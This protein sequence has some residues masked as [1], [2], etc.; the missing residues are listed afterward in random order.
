MEIQ[1]KWARI[2]EKVQRYA[3][4]IEGDV[5]EIRNYIRAKYGAELDK[6]AREMNFN[7]EFTVEMDDFNPLLCTPVLI[8]DFGKLLEE[9]EK[10]ELIAEIRRRMGEWGEQARIKVFIKPFLVGGVPKNGD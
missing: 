4:E 6:I 1:E 10:Q 9:R 8:V 7:Y 3:K 2:F 5:L